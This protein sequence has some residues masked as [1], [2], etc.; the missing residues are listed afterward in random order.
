[1]DDAVIDD[2]HLDWDG[3]F[4]VRDLGGLPATDGRPI[5]R[6]AVV[7]GDQANRLT[8]AGWSALEAHG[9]RTIIDL[10]DPT[11]RRPDAA[12]RPAHLTTIELPLEDQAD[13]EFW[14]HWRRFSC[15]PLYY[16]PFLDH[17]SAR[18]AA[19]FA[20]IAEAD[21]GGVLVHCGA[22]RDRTGLVTLVL[23]AL[24]G[25]SPE[26]IAADHALSADRL[27]PLFAREGRADE[28]VGAQEQLRRA[29]TSA[30]AE[31]LATLAS[32]DATAY[33]RAGGLRSDQLGTIS[34]RLL[35]DPDGLR[36]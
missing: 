7:R 20:A 8:A 3:C 1:V 9:V 28:D 23:L 32:L 24:L 2:R 26:L 34:R 16:R 5:R 15:T 18:M 30:R 33:L 25:V 31:I 10:R 12:P 4:N 27:R 22:G 35:A 13:N 11:E 6:G 21:P 29:N 17:A 14:H 19:V 36:P